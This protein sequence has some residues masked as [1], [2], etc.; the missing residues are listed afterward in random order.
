[1][2]I[3]LHLVL[4]EE[5]LFSPRAPCPIS[6]LPGAPYLPV[7]PTEIVGSYRVT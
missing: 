5:G 4:L 2:G 1:M 3:P 6:R 7:S